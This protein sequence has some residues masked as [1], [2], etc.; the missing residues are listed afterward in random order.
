M[1][2]DEY[3]KEFTEEEKTAFWDDYNKS[4]ITREDF[5]AQYSLDHECCP[6]CG[7]TT[8]STTL[9]QY[10]FYSD[11]PGTFEDKNHCTCKCGDTH[12]T[13]ERVVKQ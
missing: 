12:S 1:N 4:K 7:A 9:V 10:P 3:L 13:H 2:V 8:H 6:K 11:H 5:M